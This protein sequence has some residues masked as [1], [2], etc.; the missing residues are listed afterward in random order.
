MGKKFLARG[1]GTKAL[2]QS[3]L[4]YVPYSE[5]SSVRSKV[6]ERRLGNEIGEGPGT[7]PHDSYGDLGSCS[8]WDGQSLESEQGMT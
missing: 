1:T 2:R 3:C 8:V 5:E 7:K 6:G 4:A